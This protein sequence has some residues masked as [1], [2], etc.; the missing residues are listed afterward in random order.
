[1]RGGLANT[2]TQLSRPGKDSLTVAF[3]GGSITEAANGW[4]DG[5]VQWLQQQTA[6]PVRSINAAVGGTGSTLGVY[7][8]RKDVLQHKPQLLFI[9]FAVNDASDKRERILESMEGIVRQT[10]LMLPQTDICF[11]YTL[12]AAMAPHYEGSGLPTSVKAMEDL[13]KHYNIPSINLAP[14]ILNLARSGALFFAGQKPISGDTMF[15]SRDGVHPI[16]RNRLPFV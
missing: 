14:R 5:T 4:R 9:E 13:A 10:W 16:Y 6:R 1:V 3:F 12:S 11:V 8:L 7:R 15:F 2:Q